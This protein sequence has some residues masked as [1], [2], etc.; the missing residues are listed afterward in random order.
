MKKPPPT[1]HERMDSLDALDE[2]VQILRTFSGKGVVL[3]VSL[4][5]LSIDGLEAAA[6]VQR[7]AF[8]MEELGEQLEAAIEELRANGG[9]WAT[10][11]FC[12][13]TT[14]EAARQRWG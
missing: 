5:R 1:R 10:V 6:E 12:V 11:G 9:S 4:R 3:P 13:G 8:T 2:D 7:I 14:G